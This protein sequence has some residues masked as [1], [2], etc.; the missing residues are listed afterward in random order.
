MNLFNQPLRANA[1][2]TVLVV[3]CSVVPQL[4]TAQQGAQPAIQLWRS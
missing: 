2:T 3:L 4:A 1:R